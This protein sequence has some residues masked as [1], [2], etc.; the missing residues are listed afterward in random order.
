M[1]F[2]KHINDEFVIINI[3]HIRIQSHVRRLFT[4]LVVLH[5]TKVHKIKDK[6]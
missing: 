3:V 2:Q 1:I 6:T 5:I 4:L